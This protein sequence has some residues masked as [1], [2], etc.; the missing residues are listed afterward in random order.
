MSRLKNVL[1]YSSTGI[2]ASTT[3]AIICPSTIYSQGRKVSGHNWQISIDLRSFSRMGNDAD[4]YL[5]IFLQW[6]VAKV[7]CAWVS[8]LSP[9]KEIIPSRCHMRH[10]ASQRTSNEVHPISHKGYCVHHI[11][12]W[13]CW[14]SDIYIYIYARYC[15][16][17]I[18]IL[19]T[20]Y[21]R[22]DLMER[23]WY[24]LEHL[25]EMNPEH[26]TGDPSTLVHVGA[27]CFYA[28]NHSPG[29]CLQSVYNENRTLRNKLQWKFI[30]N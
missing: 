24:L 20:V 19:V 6:C 30:Q 10:A 22:V 17:Y 15:L 12:T 4:L 8:K 13:G 21:F 28:P 2:K 14:Y 23:C 11:F 3:K 1:G 16:L 5:C 29:Q 18:Y 26:L 27:W 25:S 9:L 7:Q